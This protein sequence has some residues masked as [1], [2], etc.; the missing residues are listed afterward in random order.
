[1]NFIFF[2]EIFLQSSLS[3]VSNCLHLKIRDLK[4]KYWTFEPTALSEEGHFEFFKRTQ[5]PKLASASNDH[6]DKKTF[7]SSALN[8]ERTFFL[9]D[10]RGLQ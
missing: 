8:L 10:N 5:Q 3:N 2:L 1:M 7:S 9:A 4:T 6:R